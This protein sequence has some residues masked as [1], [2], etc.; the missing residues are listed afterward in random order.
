MEEIKK[1]AWRLRWCGVEDTPRLR[2][3]V[4]HCKVFPLFRDADAHLIGSEEY[5]SLIKEGTI[6]LAVAYWQIKGDEVGLITK[7]PY[8]GKFVDT[9][10]LISSAKSDFEDGWKACEKYTQMM[11]DWDEAL[12]FQTDLLRDWIRAIREDKQRKRRS[13][14]YS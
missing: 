7:D 14:C 8:Y 13:E 4:E 9:W 1:Y 11:S 12:K 10:E 6:S 2:A 5:Q 3:T